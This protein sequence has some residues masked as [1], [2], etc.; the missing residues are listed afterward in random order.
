MAKLLTSPQNILIDIRSVSRTVADSFWLK[1][2][3]FEIRKMLQLLLMVFMV[4]GSVCSQLNCPIYSAFENDPSL[5]N[6]KLIVFSPNYQSLNKSIFLSICRKSMDRFIKFLLLVQT[7]L[8]V[9]D[10]NLQSDQTT[11][12]WAAI[13]N[14]LIGVW[15]WPTAHLIP[16]TMSVILFL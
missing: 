10:R 16:I 15:V 11:I 4:I 6:V 2:N 3:I 14:R 5:T 9:R 8:S 7:R 1:K 12:L 13:Y